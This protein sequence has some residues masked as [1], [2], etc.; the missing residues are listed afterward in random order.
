MQ[1]LQPNEGDLPF[2][3]LVRHD[4]GLEGYPSLLDSG[5]HVAPQVNWLEEE[6]LRAAD[7]D[8]ALTDTL[9][10]LGAVSAIGA[11]FTD[12]YYAIPHGLPITASPSE[13]DAMVR[14]LVGR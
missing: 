1:I 9:T 11:G 6:F 14:E 2:T 3:V 10:H 13:A 8:P 4:Q 5:W 7:E 12:P